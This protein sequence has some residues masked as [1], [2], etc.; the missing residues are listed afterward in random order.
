ML[1]RASTGFLNTDECCCYHGIGLRNVIGND[2]IRGQLQ[3][4]MFMGNIADWSLD[5]PYQWPARDVLLTLVGAENHDSQDLNVNKID[6]ASQSK[7]IK[8]NRLVLIHHRCMASG[9]PFRDHDGQLRSIQKQIRRVGESV[10][11][12]PRGIVCIVIE[13][14]QHDNVERNT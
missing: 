7:F 11:S 13:V 6:W 14:T 4:L 9:N 5:S 10:V 1:K 12:T 2:T 8:G 3:I